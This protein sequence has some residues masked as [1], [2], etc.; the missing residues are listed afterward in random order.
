MAQRDRSVYFHF[1]QVR[2]DE[3]VNI[4]SHFIPTILISAAIPVRNLLGSG[5]FV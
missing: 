4:H 5:L 1:L 2:A 3:T